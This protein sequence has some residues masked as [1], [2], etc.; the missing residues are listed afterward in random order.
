MK[1]IRDFLLFSVDLSR[2]WKNPVPIHYFCLSALKA[3]RATA[4]F[5][6][7]DYRR[8]QTLSQCANLETLRH[9]PRQPPNAIMAPIQ[10]ASHRTSKPVRSILKNP[11]SK[12][13]AARSD[14]QESLFATN[15]KDKRRIKHAHLMSKVTK[16]Q[17]GKPKRRR[18]SKKLVTTLDSL[19]D[20]L[21]DE[22]EDEASTAAGD[23]PEQQVNII[24][25]QSTKSRP[26][27]L[28]RRQKLDNEE[29]ARFAKN[30][31]QMASTKPLADGNGNS[32][33]NVMGSDSKIAATSTQ[34]WA[35][36]RGFISQ[37]LEKKPEF[38]QQGT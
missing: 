28:K 33:V 24:K 17:T 16:A 29:R 35:A 10:P 20:A 4:R 31:A 6:L 8:L 7:L 18:P 34:K 5:D 1:M 23:T 25:R 11:S 12:A 27:A 14:K 22:G 2:L 30:M 38:K 32:Q 19:A 15:K 3:C 13:S 37:T 36:L 9:T 26:G 21:P